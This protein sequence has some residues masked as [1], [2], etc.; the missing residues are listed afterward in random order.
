MYGMYSSAQCKKDRWHKQGR[1]SKKEPLHNLVQTDVSPHA[2][3]HVQKTAS[4]QT[5]G[6]HTGSSDACVRTPT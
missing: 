2:L 6:M 3:L 1:R 4:L 5:Q